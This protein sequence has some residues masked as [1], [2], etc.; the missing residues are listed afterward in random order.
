[1]KII[2][3]SKSPRRKEIL[4]MAGYVFDIKISDVDENVEAKDIKEMSYK[5]AKK[6]CDSIANDY[7]HDLVIC[8][9]TIVVIE[10]KVLG[11]PRDKEE[12]RKMI[13]TLQG[14]THEVYTSVVL[15][16]EDQEENFTEITKVRIGKLTDEEIEAYIN[17]TE[18]Y[19]KAGG[20]AIQGIFGK[21]VESIEGDYYNVMGL[22]IYRL[23]K[24]I[25]EKFK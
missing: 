20:Y 24:I 8:A 5:I 13:Q 2:L 6:K 10:G 18:P 15:K 19:D 14:K 16:K 21:Y 1:M 17:T 7:P 25:Q 12:A 9:D 4:A 23:N 3:G 22:P 11:K